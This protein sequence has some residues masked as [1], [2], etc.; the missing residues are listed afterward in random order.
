[1]GFIAQFYANNDGFQLSQCLFFIQVPYGIIHDEN[2]DGFV[3][4]MLNKYFINLIFPR[5]YS[6][7]A[8]NII[9]KENLILFQNIT[10]INFKSHRTLKVYC[11]PIAFIIRAIIEAE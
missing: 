8:I 4:Y 3:H 2:R 1:M 11:L 7:F 10:S 9:L 5:L 6:Y